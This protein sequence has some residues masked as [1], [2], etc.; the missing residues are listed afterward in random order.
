MFELC[1]GIGEPSQTNGRPRKALEDMLF[2]CV[3][4]VYST[5]SSRRFT[6]DIREAKK[7]GFIGDV[8]HFNSI[9]R[10]LDNEMVT[11][12]LQMLIEESSLPL[13]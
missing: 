7:K 13:I 9:S 12:Y 8:P 2:A 5:F 10:Y 1:N 11:P 3:F 4:K 6:T